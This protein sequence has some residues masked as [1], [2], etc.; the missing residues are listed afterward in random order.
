MAVR[1]F[2]AEDTHY[3]PGYIWSKGASGFYDTIKK[4]QAGELY[5]TAHSQTV[6]SGEFDVEFDN[7]PLAQ[8]TAT[9]VPSGTYYISSVTATH[10]FVTFASSPAG[11]DKTFPYK[12]GN[13]SAIL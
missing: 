4:I 13:W 5:L 7:A 2:I 6:A 11:A 9:V 10:I 1:T 12:V 8:F 3:G